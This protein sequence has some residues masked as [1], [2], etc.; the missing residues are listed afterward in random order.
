MVLADDDNGQFEQG[1]QRQD[2]FGIVCMRSELHAATETVGGNGPKRVN[3]KTRTLTALDTGYVV[4]GDKCHNP[5]SADILSEDRDSGHGRRHNSFAAMGNWRIRALKKCFAWLQ[6]WECPVKKAPNAVIVGWTDQPLAIGGR[7]IF[8]QSD[9]TH[10]NSG[11][12]QFAPALA[13]FVVVGF[14][15]GFIQIKHL[16]SG[17]RIHGHDAE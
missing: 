15:P 11:I 6:L 10:A 16:G 12:E 7:I 3:R 4:S 13:E 1:H 14:K 17:L 8:G 5:P 9:V 2:L